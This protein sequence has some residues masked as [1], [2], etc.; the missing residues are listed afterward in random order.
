MVDFKKLRDKTKKA[1]ASKGTALMSMKDIEDMYAVDAK[2]A[3]DAAPVA[4][5]PPLISTKG[6][7]FQIGENI[8]P[9]M[10]ELIVVAEGVLRTYYDSDYDP[11]Q[12]SPPACFAVAVADKNVD[13]TIVSHESSPNRQGGKDFK[14]Q[15]CEMNAFGTAE[16]G[17]GKACGEYRRLAVVFSDDKALS[18]GEGN[19]TWGYLNLSPTA[20]GDWGKFV[21]GLERVERR[22]PHG[23][24]IKFTFD[25]KNPKEQMRKRV[26]AIGY[27][28]ISDPGVA[29]R[30]LKLRK[31]ILES[32][33]LTRPIPV[34]G[35]VAPGSKPAP[36][37]RGRATPAKKRAAIAPAVKGKA[38]GTGKRAAGF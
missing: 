16:R 36:V 30:I 14:C 35:Y 34:D 19:I 21:Q 23:V 25:R 9:D 32:N 15:G 33:T 26:I 1:K 17:K 38:A 4:G 13:A 20:L 18:S 11:D 28:K 22:P 3:A 27:Q 6:E 29:S 2:V 24:I 8:L 31:E 10:L 7:Q 12:K 37:A 5:G